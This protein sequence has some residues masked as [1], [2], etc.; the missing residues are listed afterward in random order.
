M[1]DRYYYNLTSYFLVIAN[2]LMVFTAVEFTQYDCG[3]GGNCAPLCLSAGLAAFH[4]V[5]LSSSEIRAQVASKTC[6]HRNDGD[7]WDQVSFSPTTKL[8]FSSIW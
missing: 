1:V 7:Y 6:Q 8:I 2:F 3:G 5:F 4:N